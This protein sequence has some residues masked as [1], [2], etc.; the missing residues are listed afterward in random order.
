MHTSRPPRHTGPSRVWGALV[1]AGL[2]TVVVSGIETGV[3]AGVATGAATGP[4]E[5]S[6]AQAAATGERTY[7]VRFTDALPST[8]ADLEI[9]SRS[10]KVTRR[11]SRV[12]NGAIIS[13]PPGQLKQL[14]Q[15][16]SVL[17][18]E[19]DRAV[20]TQTTVSP[21]D[22][23]GLDRIDQRALPLSSSYSY[24]TT[25]AGVDAY[26]VD[27]G[28]LPT[29]SQFGSR[30]RAGFDAF[31][32]TT[33]DCHGHGTHVAGTVGG[34]SLGVAPEVSLVA[35]RVLDCQ[36]AGTVSGVVAGIDWAITDHTSTPAVMNLSLGGTTS[37]AL[38]SA[39]TRARGDGIVVV[40]AAG[41]ANVDACTTSPASATGDALIVGAVSIS[42][43]RSSF[44][45]FG[46]CLDMFAPGET[47][48]SAGIASNSATAYSSGTSMATP[49]VT[50]LAARLLSANPSA[51]P[52]V[53]MAA[54]IAD[55]TQGA[56]S[57]AG[58]LSPN[59]LAYA[60]APAGTGTPGTGTPATTPTTTAP[61]S[62]TTV[63]G[64]STSTPGAGTP[65]TGTPGTTTP[66]PGT[67]D[68]SVPARTSR[69]TALAGAQ[70]AYL[71][72]SEPPEL[73]MPITAHL[74][75]VY[76]NNVLIK[77][78]RVNSDASHE[79][80]GLRA[81]S[82]HTFSVANENGHGVGE[83]S[84]RSN[85]VIPLKATKVFTRP[86]TGAGKLAPPNAPTA[87]R[88]VRIGNAIQVTWRQPSNA[89]TITYEIWFARAGTYVARVVTTANGGIR[90]FGLK[91]GRYTVR[92]RA[93]NTV[94]D[95][96]LSS[97]APAQM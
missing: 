5:L 88:A 94:G 82:S 76:R 16:P 20:T 17:W 18:V 31:G 69:P 30:V 65:G 85:T 51:S 49:H 47:I 95:G 13:L 40:G 54:L 12:F 38:D 2:L 42:D 23:W 56:V 9:T 50:G 43:A 70:R 32:G 81:G 19:E 67:P 35:V 37:A 60:A 7:I 84:P 48:L 33:V 79:I 27:T 8:T 15:S 89:E 3:A 29:H 39:I 73:T 62:T 55:A 26:I 52:T 36:G 6:T 46:A 58:T 91:K 10:G 93:V 75:R 86:K 4:G 72:W 45:N 74:V 59:R 77:T 28:I 41:N 64:G 57:A 68:S 90:V 25:G 80:A 34:I 24:D 1:V 14:Q 11:L 66:T 53:V 44:S 63:P 22:S 71:E 92:V 78:V 61:A 87:V 97:S 83:F 21:V 96:L